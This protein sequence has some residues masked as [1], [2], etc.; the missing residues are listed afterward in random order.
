[1]LATVIPLLRVPNFELVGTDIRVVAKPLHGAG[2]RLPPAIHVLPQPLEPVWRVL[3]L[4][5]Y[6]NNSQNS[7]VETSEA[8]NLKESIKYYVEDGHDVDYSG[9]DETL[10][11]DEA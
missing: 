7:N 5:N 3:S 8:A 2:V 1:M 9:E 10:Y 6:E 11:D 4:A